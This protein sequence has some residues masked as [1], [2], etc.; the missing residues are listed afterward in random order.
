MASWLWQ[1][2]ST[3]VLMQTPQYGTIMTLVFQ[4]FC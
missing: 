2:V 3:D 1:Y 4:L